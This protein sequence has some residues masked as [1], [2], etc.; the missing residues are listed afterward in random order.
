ML[1]S[2]WRRGSSVVVLLCFVATLVGPAP[3][4]AENITRTMGGAAGLAAGAMGGA[5]LSTAIMAAVPGIAAMGPLATLLVSTS[6]V[7]AG[8]WIGAKVFSRLGLELDRAMGPK[9]VWA[10]L[11]ASLGAVAAMALIPAAGWFAGPMGLVAKALIGGVLGGSL[12]A[13]F[14]KQL[15]AVAT[16]RTIYAAAGGAI[17]AFAGGVP[18]ALA[19]VA[20]GYAV[21]TVLD[22]NFMADEDVTLRDQMRRG[23]RYTE[24]VYDRAV[25]YH[26]D[27]GDW[28]HNR[29]DRFEERWNDHRD[30]YDQ[31][32]DSFYWEHDFAD[33]GYEASQRPGRHEQ[34]QNVRKGRHEER[35][36][37]FDL[38]TRWQEE[39]ATYEEL[40]KNPDT[41]R[42]DMQRALKR[43]QAAEQAYQQALRASQNY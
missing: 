23:Y 13:L 33:E 10:M 15:E 40:H 3:A 28:V 16:P 11:G 7:A 43:V 9:A 22:N 30:Y 42:A 1:R 39:L 18:G 38:K 34:D 14:N 19:G 26:E 32:E 36:D 8:G 21:G 4:R 17:G 35:Q 41:N 29:V 5:A 2:F 12:G 27:I 24:R 31:C 37:L 25:D 20:G 6:I